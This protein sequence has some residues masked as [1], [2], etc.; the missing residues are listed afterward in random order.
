VEGSKPVV[1]R[2]VEHLHTADP[3]ELRLV[4]IEGP[5]GAGKS[6]LAAAVAAR[7][8]ARHQ[9][10]ITVVHGDDFFG[11]VERRWL[12]GHTPPRE[13]LSDGYGVFAHARLR[14]ELLDPLRAGERARYQRYDWASDS[15]ADWLSA[16]PQGV[17]LV[18]GAYVLRRH[19]RHY[20]DEALFVRT[21]RSVRHARMHARRQN[22]SGW[23]ERWVAAEDAYLAA[24][25]PAAAANLIVDGA[26]RLRPPP[27][28]PR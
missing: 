15:L 23:I 3:R 24:E 11:P 25:D 16:P 5:G 6:T 2:V 12:D 17:V 22:A 21:P 9:S 1:D 20:W 27:T 8:R 14:R 4:C 10:E 19:L 18:E 26:S 28:A 7:Y 13:S